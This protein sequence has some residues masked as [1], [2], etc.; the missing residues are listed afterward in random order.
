VSGIYTTEGI[1]FRS[2]KFKESSMITDIY[3]ESLG[4][5]SFIIGGVRGRKQ[6]GKA[7]I[8]H[9][10]NIVS[11]TAYPSKGDS[12]SRIKEITYAKHFQKIN[13]DVIVSMVSAFIM[14]ICQRS[15]QEPEQNSE[16]YTFLK[17]RLILLD[18]PTTP[19]KVFHLKFLLELSNYL[20]FA[21]YN[22]YNKQ[23]PYFDLSEGLFIDKMDMKNSICDT[24]TSYQLYSLLSK[25]IDDALD[26]RISRAERDKVLDKLILYYK[27]HIEGLGP[28]KS[29]EVLRTI[30][31]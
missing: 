20:G 21:P 29:L 18:D 10:G 16:L 13:Q 24:Q 3:T 30:L 25:R 6:A 7:N 22:N 8:F 11:L 23:N 9:P 4:L 26:L 1:V 5:K 15:I 14:E 19:L 27:Y 31:S 12:L 17:S 2:L 28:I